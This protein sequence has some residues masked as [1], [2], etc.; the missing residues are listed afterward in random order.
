[1]DKIQKVSNEI[2]EC[3][4]FIEGLTTDS[5]EY[6]R[7]LEE[8]KEELERRW[9]AF[10]TRRFFVVTVG[11][12]KSGK[13]TLINALVGHRVSPDGIGAE[14]TKKC[15]V[16]MS[17]DEENPEGITLYRSPNFT[18]HSH[19]GEE[20]ENKCAKLTNT[21]ME[22]FK[23]IREWDSSLAEL[24]ERKR[25]SLHGKGLDPLGKKDNLEYVLTS[26]DFSGL[27]QFRDFFIAEIRIKVDGQNHTILNHGDHKI[28]IVDMP[29][30]D[31][32]MAGV[33][34][35]SLDSAYNPVNFLPKSCHLF[36]LV[37]SSI[38]GLNRTTAEKLKDWRSEKRST[39]VYL[40]FNTIEA[41]SGWYTGEAILNEKTECEKR[42]QKELEK[43]GVG[44]KNFLT[45][46]AAKGWEALQPQAYGSRW[47][48]GYK[49]D[50]KLWNESK[51]QELE[52]ALCKDFDEQ[53]GKII[54]EDALDGIAYG[55]KT[56]QN[57]LNEIEQR[58]RGKL[59]ELN[60]IQESWNA[61][62]KCVEE[63]SKEVRRGEIE[64]NSRNAWDRVLQD[65]RNDR[66]E[67]VEKIAMLERVKKAVTLGAK[68]PKN[69]SGK[70]SKK[71]GKDFSQEMED[72][73]EN[74]EKSVN[75][76]HMENDFVKALSDC[77]K[78]GY[79]EGFFGRL[80]MELEKLDRSGSAVSVKEVKES[81]R[82]YEKW[83]DATEEL[84]KVFP[85]IQT[86]QWLDRKRYKG[87]IHGPWFGF[88][89]KERREDFE[90]KCKEGYENALCVDVK[91]KMISYCVVSDMNGDSLLNRR[92][93]VVKEHLEKDWESR[94]RALKKELG[95][96]DG[97]LRTVPE[98][99]RRLGQIQDDCKN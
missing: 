19:K 61:V 52:E 9:R 83:N 62:M 18:T 63:V 28:A 64:E 68:H 85:K 41:K 46:N 91:E 70:D 55:M 40:V 22:Y 25:V 59:Q 66:D 38:S 49:K 15:S 24:F 3:L 69:N 89:K 29:G 90:A 8:L 51:V 58:A 20:W 16:V 78:A 95:Q 37:Q 71:G 30:L 42:A 48:E 72:M 35:T 2:C 44:Y 11:A 93:N 99:R 13:S 6:E 96:L 73:A 36:L 7:Y 14:T 39:P 31:G 47:Q 60:Q 33:N 54:Q 4:Q 75:A 57:S 77:L 32:M 23:G 86:G 79:E 80:S 76:L 87:I 88:G 17:A 12:L 26:E 27:Q 1:M 43:R 74:I 81:I 21:L 53:L 94:G 92:I 82:R 45:I 56:Y 98:L 65:K 34:A 84:L 97:V 50:T 10:N 67:R 5:T